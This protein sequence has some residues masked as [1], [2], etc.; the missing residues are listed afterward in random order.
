MSESREAEIAR[1]IATGDRLSGLMNRKFTVVP[2][3]LAN[4]APA[5]DAA[6]AVSRDIVWECDVCAWVGIADPAICPWCGRSDGL[7]MFDYSEHDDEIA[8]PER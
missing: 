7:C 3:K 4:F 6:A 2:W 5:K 1:I 8:P